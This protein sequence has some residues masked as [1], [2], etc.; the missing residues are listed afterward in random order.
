LKP[1][2]VVLC[3]YEGK[4]GSSLGV[5]EV[6]LMVWTVKRPSLFLVV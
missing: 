5:V 4:S 3:N 2:N 1:H 6:D